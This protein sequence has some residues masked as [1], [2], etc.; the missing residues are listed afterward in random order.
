MVSRN[1]LIVPDSVRG[2]QPRSFR[3]WVGEARQL[4]YEMRCEID[5]AEFK[6]SILLKPVTRKAKTATDRALGDTDAYITCETIYD[7]ARADMA[8]QGITPPPIENEPKVLA[9]AIDDTA[10]YAMGMATETIT[11]G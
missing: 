9:F 7:K 10:A 6:V 11:R 3:E 5:R 8:D 4:G 1:G 2:R